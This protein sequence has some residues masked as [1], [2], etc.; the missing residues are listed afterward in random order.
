MA[1]LADVDDLLFYA[2]TVWFCVDIVC[3]DV[4]DEEMERLQQK[5]HWLCYV[6]RILFDEFL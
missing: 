5:G 3:E 6:Q 1:V 4:P 2:T